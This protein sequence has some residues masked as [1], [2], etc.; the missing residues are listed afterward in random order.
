MRKRDLSKLA[1]MIEEF[2][3]DWPLLVADEHLGQHF[4]SLLQD[5][6][7]KEVFHEFMVPVQRDG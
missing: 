1:A 6:E 4:S 5:E 3:R 2:Q 7:L